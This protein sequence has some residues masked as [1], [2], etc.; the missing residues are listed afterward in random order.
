[1]PFFAVIPTEAAASDV[2]RKVARL[3]AERRDPFC[4][5]GRDENTETQRGFLKLM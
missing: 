5:M 2:V 3:A 4:M 1:M